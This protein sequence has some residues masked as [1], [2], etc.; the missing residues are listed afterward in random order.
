MRAFAL[1]VFLLAAPPAQKAKPRAASSAKSVDAPLNLPLAP[2]SMGQG[3]AASGETACAR[4]HVTTSWTEV[5]FNHDRTGFPLTGGHS[6]VSCSGCH[7]QDFK[8]PVPTTCSGC[9]TDVH[10]ADLGTRCEGCHDTASWASRF[11]A[12]AHRRTDFPLVGAH[13]VIPCLECHSEATSGRRFARAA[14]ECAA[15][16]QADLARTQ[17]TP[18]DHAALGFTGTCRSCH[19]AFRFKPARFPDHDRCYPISTGAHSNIACLGC[20]TS[21]SATAGGRACN[22]GT[23]ACTQCHEH[24]CSA[25]GGTL[26]TDQIH[27]KV[28]GYQCGDRR[29]Y[30]CHQQVIK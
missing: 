17:G 10:A 26:R 18:L 1:L 24:L 20:H 3:H 16:H 14:V 30:E 9:H 23:A 22:T 4:C 2:Q 29:C 25:P 21:L 12:D 11:E 28:P 7:A 15:C 6:S 19:N 5:R 27:A 8:R 13:A